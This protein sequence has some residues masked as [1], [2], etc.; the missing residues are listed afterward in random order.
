MSDSTDF[1]NPTQARF[2]IVDININPETGEEFKVYSEVIDPE[3]KVLE[4]KEKTRE[5][6]LDLH[7]LFETFEKVVGKWSSYITDKLEKL[8]SDDLS[9]IT[10]NFV[11]KEPSKN[12]LSPQ[13]LYSELFNLAEHIKLPYH[14]A[15][16][17][18]Y[19]ETSKANSRYLNQKMM[20][21]AK[22]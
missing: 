4:A 19:L 6:A 20:N 13:T 8:N 10:Y 22:R 3:K 9:K 1:N 7:Q 12:R 18:G 11:T 5:R 21:Y 15:S 17:Q 2:E 16:I 14:Q